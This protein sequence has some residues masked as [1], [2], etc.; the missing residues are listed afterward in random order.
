MAQLLML[1]VFAPKPDVPWHFKTTYKS[2]HLN[3]QLRTKPLSA[4]D[5]YGFWGVL[6]LLFFFF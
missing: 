4:G 5:M 2:S 3:V 1:R 6:V